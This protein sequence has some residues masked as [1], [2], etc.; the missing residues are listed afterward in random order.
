MLNALLL[1]LALGIGVRL[2]GPLG[3]LLMAAAVAVVGYRWTK[4]RNRD[5]SPRNE[6][7]KWIFGTYANWAQYNAQLGE[8]NP[9]GSLPIERPDTTS[10]PFYI[11]G[12]PQ[13]KGERKYYL[14]MLD[15][16][17]DIHSKRDLLE[18]VEYMSR[19]PGFQKCASQEDRAWELCRC[20][21]LL[22]IA[23]RLGWIS[24]GEMLRRSCEVG[25]IIQKTF[26][27]WEEMSRC[28][29][30]S[31]LEWMGSDRGRDLRKEIHENLW[32]R[33]DSPYRLP[34]NLPLG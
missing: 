25:R 16:P 23:F 2:G 4:G 29:L 27:G 15:S 28:F 13:G 9:D 32:E 24:R 12:R 26:S 6:V 22:S 20:N 10:S 7:E 34:W 1:G 33:R 18:T 19:G 17:W 8:K 3:L 30:S 31:C 21:Q 5:I 14:D 11:G